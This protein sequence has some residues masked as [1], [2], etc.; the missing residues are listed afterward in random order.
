MAISDPAGPGDEMSSVTATEAKNALGAVL[1]RVLV[2][3][4]IAITRHDEVKAV[5]LSVR[6]YEAL[7]AAQ[8]DP[9]EKLAAEFDGLVERMQRPQARKA[10]RSLFE[11]SAE[12]LGDAAMNVASGGD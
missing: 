5:V 12:E 9:L 6:E 10:G 11:A 2:E 4:R 3:G 1:E 7:K 8:H